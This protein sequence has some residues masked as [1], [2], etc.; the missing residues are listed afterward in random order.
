[1]LKNH[2]LIVNRVNPTI[3]KILELSAAGKTEEV[4]NLC[5]Y[6]HDL[7]M[8]EQKAFSGNELKDFLARANQILKYIN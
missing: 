3:K 4:K 2:T 8:L 5:A 1:M 7:S 6:I